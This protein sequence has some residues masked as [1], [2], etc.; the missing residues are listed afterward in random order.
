MES[1][2]VTSCGTPATAAAALNQVPEAAAAEGRR[3]LWRGNVGRWLRRMRWLA[4]HLRQGAAGLPHVY[5]AVAVRLFFVEHLNVNGDPMV[6]LLT[7]TT[8]EQ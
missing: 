3:P 1:A 6:Q 5:L 4:L 8:V 2:T 7:T